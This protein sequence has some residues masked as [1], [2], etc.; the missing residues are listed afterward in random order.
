MSDASRGVSASQ[1][2]ISPPRRQVIAAS[3]ELIRLADAL[4]SPGPVATRGV[5]QAWI[6]LTDGTGP[7]YNETS[8]ANL[9]TRAASAA[10]NLHLED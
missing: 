2:R 6:L 7:L 9:R 8:A 4:A 5:A 3:D 10:D 1:A